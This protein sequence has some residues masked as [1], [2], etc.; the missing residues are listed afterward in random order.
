MNLLKIKIK[1]ALNRVLWKIHNYDENEHLDFL[2]KQKK[3]STYP[4]VKSIEET[5]DKLIQENLSIARYGDGEFMLCFDRSIYFQ[6]KNRKLRNRLLDILQNMSN[7]KCLIALPEYRTE[8]LTTFWK[9]FWFENIKDLESILHKNKIYYNQSITRE[10][11]LHEIEKLRQIWQDRNVIFVLG[12]GSRFDFNHELFSSVLSHDIIYG[13]PLNAWNEY[14]KVLSEVKNRATEKLNPLVIAA[15][16]PAATVLAFDLSE[17]GI[18]TLDL[19]HLTN[20]YDK[21]KYGK[22]NPENLQ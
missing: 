17:S 3:T 2:I 21:L 4:K 13:L 1:R 15:L 18:Q 8:R 19:G 10:I 6:Q 11:K 9:K 7:E 20:V 16:G 22:Q 14:E 5:I 12:K